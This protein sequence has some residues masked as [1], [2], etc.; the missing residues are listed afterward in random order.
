MTRDTASLVLLAAA[1]VGAW[2]AAIVI[3]RGLREGLFDA[4]AVLILAVGL[5]PS[6]GKIVTEI[7]SPGFRYISE[8]TG[9]SVFVQSALVGRVT[10]GLLV[11]LLVL[12]AFIILHRVLAAHTLQVPAGWA[13]VL[14][15]LATVST[16]LSGYE[17]P[18]LTAATLGSALAL[19]G[20][21][22]NPRGLCFGVTLLMVFVT[23]TSVVTVLIRPETAL[24]SCRADKCGPLGWLIPGSLANENELALL[25]A[26]GLPFILIASRSRADWILALYL[27]GMAASTGSR[28]AGFAAGLTL[29]VALLFR[30]RLTERGH[31]RQ[32]RPSRRLG[33]V[34]MALA[35]AGYALPAF[36]Q[37]PYAYS[38]RAR[39]WGDGLT[40]IESARWLGLGT[41]HWRAHTFDSAASY[42]MHN[43]LL[44]VRYIAGFVG[45]ALFAGLVRSLLLEPHGRPAILLILANVAAMGTLER[46]WSIGHLDWLSFAY[47]GAVA[48]ASGQRKD[49][50]TLPHGKVGA[51]KS[52]GD[53]YD[54][55][56][57]PV[58]REVENDPCKSA[59]GSQC[60]RGADLNRDPVVGSE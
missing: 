18:W 30:P 32:A 27:G 40:F 7:T 10:S 57:L 47:V 51:V 35:V 24:T 17:P 26:A 31:H 55:D 49:A 29:V 20:T 8:G 1:V 53:D 22:P 13:L 25:L 15:T 6:A 39:I 54:L 11:T 58:R 14:L 60:C 2:A 37:S 45:L 12:A 59:R 52:A 19:A 44:D 48:V 50:P 5:A 21:T 23:L 3:L 36:V 34:V 28:T 56:A 9:R 43:Q 41:E 42:S 38:G 16:A 33:A 4:S 46:P